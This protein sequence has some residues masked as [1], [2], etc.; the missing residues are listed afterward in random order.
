MFSRIKQVLFQKENF[1]EIK[2]YIRDKFNE[3]IDFK[4]FIL[5]N[6]SLNDTFK[7]FISDLFN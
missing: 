2:F 4:V 5:S 7:Q 3:V 6:N 1:L